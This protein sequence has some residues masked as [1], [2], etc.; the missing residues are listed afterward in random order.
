MEK[1]YESLLSREEMARS[2][3]KGKFYMI[4]PDSRD[5]NYAEYFEKGQREISNFMEYNSQ[6]QRYLVSMK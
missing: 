4:P 5:L 3:D 2:I 1:N 6:I